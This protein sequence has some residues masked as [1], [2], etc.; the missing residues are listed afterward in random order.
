MQPDR[1]AQP[2]TGARPADPGNGQLPPGHLL[3]GRYRIGPRIARGGMASVYEATDLRLDRTV[4]VKVMH[5]G[6]GDDEEFA[7]R[8]VREA[9][10]AAGLSHPNVVSVYDQGRDAGVV[11]L[12]MELVSGHTLRDVIRKESPLSPARALALLEPVLSALAAAH[13]AGLIHR[14]IKPE[15]VLIAEDGR[16]KVADFG[17]AKAI[18]ADTQHTVTGGV[19]IGTVSYLAPELVVDGKADAR[20]DVYA[21]GVLLY[22]LLTGRKPHQGDSPIQVAYKHVH[23]DVPPPSRE[24]PGLPAYVDALVARATARDRVHRPADAG[25]LLH[26]VHRVA[27][28]LAEGVDDDADL[29]ADLTPLLLAGSWPDAPE[30]DERDEVRSDTAELGEAPVTEPLRRAPAPAWDDDEMAALLGPSRATTAVAVPADRTR[31]VPARPASPPGSPP[32]APPARPAAGPARPRRSR[33]GPLLLVLALL[34][35]AAVGGGAYWFG[36]ARYTSTPGVIGLAEAAAVDRLEAAGLSAELGDPAYSETVPKGRVIST[37]PEAG[38]QVLDGGTVTLVLSLGKERYDVPKLAGLTR[39]EAE[40]ELTDTSLTLGQVVERWSETVPEGTVIRSDPARGTTLRPGT[41]VD[42]VVSKGRRP[43]P[44]K[45][46]TGKDADRA[47]AAMEKRDLVVEVTGEEY[48]EVVPEGHVIS[49]DP[50]SDTL[51]KGDT[52][53]LVVSLGPPL[54]EVPS[55]VAVGV[56]E[57]TQRLKDLGFEVD[58]ENSSAYIGLGYVYSS[59]PGAGEMVPKG[60]TITLFLV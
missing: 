49:Q 20:A 40:A 47:T 57:A 45:D 43:I 18:S 34:V 12:A 60:S 14:D 1:H 48:S 56:D 9:R 7:A 24:V 44:V 16:V 26:Q 15:N 27:H 55:L 37:D 32:A 41:A 6:L 46:W 51:F 39:G 50:T 35:V 10:A 42:L 13:R 31:A 5:A 59:D 52:V 30:A 4:A 58:V 17:L 28:A 29:T 11:Y 8:F 22:E 54:V 38:A 19:L 36:W 3:D 33:R 21:V 25:V 53:S 2:G 23:E